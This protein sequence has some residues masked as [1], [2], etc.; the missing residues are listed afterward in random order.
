M[1]TYCLIPAHLADE[2]HEPLRRWF[3]D[4]PSI[5]VVVERRGV[6]RRAT[7]E[8]GDDEAGVALMSGDRRRQRDRR[9][10]AEWLAPP[11]L[12]PRLARYA[13]QLVFL[14]VSAESPVDDR[15]SADFLRL[16]VAGD[17]EAI[18]QIY[19][20]YFDRIYA[21]L[22]IMLT[23]PHDA[24]DATQEVFAKM[25]AA[26]PRYEPRGSP[27]R[28]WLFRIAQ[29]TALD[30][31]RRSGRL[32]ATD[33]A[34]LEADPSRQAPGADV[35]ALEWLSDRQVLKLVERLPRRQREVIVL[36]YLGDLTSTEIAALVGATP[37]AVRQLQHRAIATL[38]GRLTALRGPGGRRNWS[39]MRLRSL[40][41]LRS[42]RFALFAHDWG[43]P[44]E[45][46]Q[47]RHPNFA[48]TSPARRA[49]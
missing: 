30:R 8:G 44:T 47:L 33:P 5:E 13:S 2:L 11:A 9:A 38:R 4:R 40:P 24:E 32:V 46:R 12:S 22:R 26:L 20:R 29:R 27:L 14:R 35:T 48:V 10:A 7:A 34:E 49:F 15:E 16:L 41:V 45:P 17:R 6:D 19:L 28:A 36:R 42:R 25:L 37:A 21:Y 39:R 23:R 1:I 31:L 18:E 3:A 43:R